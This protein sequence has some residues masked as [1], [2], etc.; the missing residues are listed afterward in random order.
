MP[1]VASTLVNIPAT[2]LTET[3]SASVATPAAGHQKL[4]ID[5]DHVLKRKNSAGTVA[6]VEGLSNPM[7]T[8]GDLILGGVSG[9]A[10]RL[11]IGTNTYVLTSNGTTA[12]W[13]AASGGSLNDYICIT[14]QKTANT[15]AGTFTSGAWR[16]R[17]L[18]TEQSDTGGHASVASNQIT[19]AAGTY[20]ASIV[21]PAVRVVGHQAKL[22]N[23]TDA[24]N[25]LIG[26]SG[27]SLS[28]D[29]GNTH[30]FIRGKFSIAGSKVLEV[31]HKSTATMNTYGFG[32]AGG[33]GEVEIYTVVELWKVA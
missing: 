1:T 31:Q 24:A 5:T 25:I 16:T 17:D 11:A 8:A 21:C 18:N 20:I 14:D 13:A 15:N 33:S 29:D 6:A 4:F 32:L 19:L 2:D 3:A 28:A 26:T 30:S 22:Y 27:Y 12:A 10:G 7:T 9:A 23:V